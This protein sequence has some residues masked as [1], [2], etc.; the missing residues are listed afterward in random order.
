[1]AVELQFDGATVGQLRFGPSPH[2]EILGRW[3]RQWN[4]A[5]PVTMDR[6]DTRFSRRHLAVVVDEAWAYLAWLKGPVGVVLSTVEG[7]RLTM[8]RTLPVA[9]PS[10][11]GVI[12]FVHLPRE[13]DIAWRLTGGQRRAEV[14]ARVLAAFES[15]LTR[16]WAPA[17]TRRHDAE[18]PTLGESLSREQALTIA[19]MTRRYRARAAGVPRTFLSYD[20]ADALM[21]KVGLTVKSRTVVQVVGRRL[22]R[23]WGRHLTKA[24]VLQAILDDP[25]TDL[26]I[27]D[28]D[29]DRLLSHGK[30]VRGA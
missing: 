27:A 24:E 19:L 16:P 20:E 25:E 5:A 29:L 15:A 14:P 7:T 12:E 26:R 28:A 9:L 18:Y 2:P 4:Q 21:D 6:S 13:F 23:A 17:E 11:A 3:T 30:S 10:T 8:R 1:M 22:S